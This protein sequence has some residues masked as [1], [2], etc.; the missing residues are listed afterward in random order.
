MVLMTMLYSYNILLL[1]QVTTCNRSH[2]W[3]GPSGS[4]QPRLITIRIPVVLAYDNALPFSCG[5]SW[6]SG[7]TPQHNI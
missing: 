3:I 4:H 6:E 1:V 5:Y 7:E 2:T